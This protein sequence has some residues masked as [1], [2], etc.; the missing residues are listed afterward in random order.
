MLSEQ[1]FLIHLSHLEKPVL[2]PAPSRTIHGC[3]E[4]ISQTF[5][6]RARLF[7]MEEDGE[8]RKGP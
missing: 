7:P 1:N 6:L 4:Q 5:R 3:L 8:G 2:M